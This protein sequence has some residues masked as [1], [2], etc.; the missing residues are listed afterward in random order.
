MFAGA[1]SAC[2]SSAR[3]LA[4]RIIEHLCYSYCTRTGIGERK[5]A[6]T[7]SLSSRI[8]S[9]SDFSSFYSSYS[10]LTC[11]CLFFF[12]LTF[13]YFH[14][15]SS[16]FCLFFIFTRQNTINPITPSLCL[17]STPRPFPPLCE[18]QLE[19][20]LE[21][22]ALVTY[23]SLCV[24]MLALLLTVLVLSCLRGLKSNTRSIHS[25]TAA[26][27]FL[28]ELVFL[29]GVNQTEQQVGVVCLCRCSG[30]GHIQ[31][32]SKA[33]SQITTFFFSP[34]DFFLVCSNVPYAF[35]PFFFSTLLYRKCVRVCLKSSESWREGA[36][37]MC[38][39]SMKSN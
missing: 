21:T 33:I 19:G 37:N 13:F 22:L 26:A 23:S 30:I 8:F 4:S 17:L 31:S 28:S 20:D 12:S 7:D 10:N 36:E 25:N 5:V 15:C 38:S 18:Q 14:Y 16:P 2:V 11:G 34:W 39:L 35:P 32:L 9:L 1:G 29:L 6:L 27:M 3:V 24:S